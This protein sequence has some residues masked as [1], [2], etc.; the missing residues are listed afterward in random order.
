VTKLNV[1]LNLLQYQNLKHYFVILGR[2]KDLSYW[3][4]LTR[5]VL[6]YEEA[7]LGSNIISY[8]LSPN[9]YFI[10]TAAW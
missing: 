10:P 7:D 9:F 4:I 2:Y 8:L 1:I 3:E 6:S 5:D